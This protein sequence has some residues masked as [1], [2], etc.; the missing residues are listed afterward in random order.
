MSSLAFGRDE[1]ADLVERLRADGYVWV[2]LVT[3][4]TGAVAGHIRYPRLAIE[5]DGSAADFRD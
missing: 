2:E 4:Q 3:R 5:R 1:E